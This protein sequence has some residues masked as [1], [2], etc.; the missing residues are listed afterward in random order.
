[1][2]KKR[3]L[4]HQQ[5]RRIQKNQKQHIESSSKATGENSGDMKN[6]QVLANFGTRTIIDDGEQNTIT[7][8][9]RKNLGT[10]ITGDRVTWQKASTSDPSCEGVIVAVHDRESVLQ[11]PGFGGKHKPMAANIDQ[12]VVVCSVEPPPNAYLVDRYL[13]AAENLPAS[14]IIVLNKTD[15]LTDENEAT[16]DEI[17]SIYSAIGYPVLETCALSCAGIEA[18]RKHLVGHTSILVGLSGVGKSSLIKDLVADVDIRIGE[19]SESSGEGRHTT[20][21]SM[22]YVL[23][24]HSAI[25]DSPGVRDFGLWEHRHNDILNG[26]VELK[27]LIGQ[28][29]FSNCTHSSEP[30]CVIRNSLSR[31]LICERRFNN[32]RKMVDE[33]AVDTH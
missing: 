33:Y 6:G 14:T 23:D 2:A 17:V 26:Y 25:I 7:C 19:L 4:T 1:M 12:V 24:K 30:G 20:T 5:N 22:L 16:V 18:L 13:V 8:S 9:V 27:A 21:A 31:E 32:Y 29:K 28:C 10:V 15:L 11:K 3:N